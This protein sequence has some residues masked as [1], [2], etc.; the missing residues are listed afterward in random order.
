VTDLGRAQTTQGQ[1]RPLAHQIGDDGKKRRRATQVRLAVGADD[2]ERGTP[3]LRATNCKSRSDAS[4]AA[5]RSS[6]T[7]TSGRAAAAACRKLVSES[8][9]PK[10]AWSGWSLAAA[11]SCARRIGLI[12][13]RSGAPAPICASATSTGVSRT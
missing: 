2:E 12:C 8:N 6:S 5:C 11:P 4:S 1:P 3:Q 10:R 13:A 9:R 7:S